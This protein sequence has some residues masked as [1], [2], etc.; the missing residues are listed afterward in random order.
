M[1]YF[2]RLE[3]VLSEHQDQQTNDN[4]Q[5]REIIDRK[6]QGLQEKQKTQVKDMLKR[7]VSHTSSVITSYKVNDNN[8][9]CTCN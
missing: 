8:V 9:T 4:I 6:I 7:Q 1:E 5:L 3:S 2:V